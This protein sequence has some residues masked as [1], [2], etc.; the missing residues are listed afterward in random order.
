MYWLSDSH[1]TDCAH[2][3]SGIITEI[4]TFQVQKHADRPNGN[5]ILEN[6]SHCVG[7]VMVTEI[8]TM[9]QMKEIVV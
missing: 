4:H 7:N 2:V 1:T 9:D 3:L 5:A 8:A 6:V